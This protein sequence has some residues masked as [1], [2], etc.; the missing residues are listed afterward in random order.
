VIF[1]KEFCKGE[2][3]KKRKIKRNYGGIPAG[4]G[5]SSRGG[6]VIAEVSRGGRGDCAEKVG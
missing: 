3:E 5:T 4:R 1:T 2:Y 6:S